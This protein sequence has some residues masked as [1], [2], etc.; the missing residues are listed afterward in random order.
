M[1]PLL[2]MYRA[3]W[4]TGLALRIPWW[5]LRARPEELRER[6]GECPVPGPAPPLWIH[7]ASV[8]ETVAAGVLIKTIRA[9]A[10]PPVALSAMT[11]TG[12]RNGSALAPD[13]GPF[14]PPLDGPEIVRRFLDRLRPRAL[15]LLETEIWPNLLV[16]LRVRSIPWAIASGRLTKR[17]ERRL[18]LVRGLFREILVGVAAV[19]ARTEEDADRFRRLGAP[20]D[21]VRVTGDLKEDRDV[22]PRGDPPDDVPRWIAACTRPGEEEAAVRATRTVAATIP[23]GELVLAPRHPERFDAAAE[24]AA[25]S[26]FA[27][28][29]WAD[30][31]VPAAAAGWTIL[32]VDEMGVLEEAYRRSRCAF[33]GG[34]LRPFGGHSP[35]EAAAAG[36]P[37]LFGPHTENC[38]DLAAR[39]ERNGGAERVADES[40]LAEAVRRLLG[41]G[42]EA[43]RR[44][45][46][47]HATVATGGGAARRTLDFLVERG[48]IR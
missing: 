39:L 8:G 30:R 43:T 5:L 18:R 24:I 6:L 34:T 12:R 4:A 36:R 42:A 14:H 44:G 3:V 29:R 47:A 13:F 16:E 22:P 32:L 33:V 37:V 1:S 45:R 2:G 20:A 40:E 23:R 7:A 9:R 48:V 38:R 46:A 10:G 31:D 28:R 25:H 17:S 21:A 35:L 15:V 27:V 26:G 41:D 19:G 11:R